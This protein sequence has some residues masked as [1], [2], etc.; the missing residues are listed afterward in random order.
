MNY[1]SDC[2][3][4]YYVVEQTIHSFIFSFTHLYLN[5]LLESQLDDQSV[6]C[7]SIGMIV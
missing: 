5:S 3:K 6:V 2:E 4:T 7:I 1:I